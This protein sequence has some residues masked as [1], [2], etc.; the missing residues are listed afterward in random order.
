M[1]VGVE[2]RAVGG[3]ELGKEEEVRAVLFGTAGIVTTFRGT[4]IGDCEGSL[5][6]GVEE[7]AEGV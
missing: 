6:P 1:L 5:S 3:A 4:A 7:G 2:D